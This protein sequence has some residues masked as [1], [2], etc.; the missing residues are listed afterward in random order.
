M[1]TEYVQ[2]EKLDDFLQN[3]NASEDRLLKVIGQIKQLND[4]LSRY[5][6]SHEDL[7]HTDILITDRGTVLTDLD[8]MKVYRV[9]WVYKLR[10]KKGEIA[11]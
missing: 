5:L 2:G 8:R 10:R 6:I 11:L 3:N 9:G 7:K 1:V 4:K